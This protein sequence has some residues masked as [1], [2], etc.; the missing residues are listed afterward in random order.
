MRSAGDIGQVF[1]IQANPSE[2][3]H[4]FK[5]NQ[6]KCAKKLLQVN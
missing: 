4:F 2:N 6:E 1:N 5:A 3:E